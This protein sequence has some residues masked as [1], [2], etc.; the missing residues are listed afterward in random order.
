MYTR[1][2]AEACLAQ[3][4]GID[5]QQSIEIVPELKLTLHDA[6]HILG[7]SIVELSCTEGDRPRTL[8]FSGDLGYRDAPVMDPPARLKNAYVVLLESTYGDR[9]HR[10]FDETIKELA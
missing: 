5:Y 10:P 7:S 9:L 4:T 3:I 2:D 6:G 1:A 8:V